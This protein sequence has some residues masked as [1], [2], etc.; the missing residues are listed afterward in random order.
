MHVLQ[1]L[2]MNGTPL[3]STRALQ[4]MR[5]LLLTLRDQGCIPAPYPPKKYLGTISGIFWVLGV[6]IEYVPARFLYGYIPD[7]YIPKGKG[8]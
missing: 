5:F 1:S 2:A 3:T 7:T 8:N 6:T 4:R